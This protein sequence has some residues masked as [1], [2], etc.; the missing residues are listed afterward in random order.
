[1]ASH[2][3]SQTSPSNRVPLLVSFLGLLIVILP[4]IYL[5]SSSGALAFPVLI[6]KFLGI[7]VGVGVASTGLDSYRTGN[8][9]PAMVTGS[10]VIGLLSVGIIGGLIET[11]GGPLIPIWLW[12]LSAVLTIGAAIILTTRLL[13]K[14]AQ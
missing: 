5:P 2:R 11:S 6:M 1:M 14:T 8:L 3:E 10:A 7:V 13:G 4:L 9:Q 12:V